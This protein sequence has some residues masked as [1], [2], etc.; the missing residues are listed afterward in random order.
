MSEK[1]QRQTRKLP[2]PEEVWTKQT[3][4]PEEISSL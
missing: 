2:N 4:S 3:L 1:I